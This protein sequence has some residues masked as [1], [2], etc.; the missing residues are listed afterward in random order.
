[1]RPAWLK[2]IA[3]ESFLIIVVWMIAGCTFLQRSSTPLPPSEAPVVEP[4]PIPEVSLKIPVL[5]K[6]EF[7]VHKVR[8]PGETLAV[9]ARW[10]TGMQKNWEVIVKVNSDFD[11][12]RMV[13]GDKILIPADILKTRKP[14]PR[15]YLRNSVPK[16]DTSSS[17]RAKSITESDKTKVLDSPEKDRSVTESKKIELFELQDTEES[18]SESNKIELFELQDTEESVPESNKIELFELVE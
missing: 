6:A 13:I 9:I 14:M 10:Y 17:S 4:E 16:R 7:Y 8:W 3:K 1:M 5:K 12:K 18:V 11:P 2:R 15:E